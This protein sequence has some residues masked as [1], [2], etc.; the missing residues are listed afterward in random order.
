MAT[1]SSFGGFGESQTTN[2]LL[3]FYGNNY[4]YWKNRK[5]YFIQAYYYEVWEIITDGPQFVTK[6]L[7][8][9]CVSKTREEYSNLDKK[10]LEMNA[11]A[12]HMIF[13]ALSPNEYNR[14]SSCY[15][16]KE[17]WDR[18][19]VT[20]KGTDQIKESK[21][22]MLVH[23]YELFKILDD[24]SITNMFTRFTNITNS[25]KSLGKS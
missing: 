14:V 3:I 11:K 23:E 1:S 17:I 20:Y 8:G 9:E 7:N 2:R 24:E 5:M 12:I 16:A 18:L 10:K 4:T 6:V 25:L 15:S 13:Y 21:I 22:S 19:E